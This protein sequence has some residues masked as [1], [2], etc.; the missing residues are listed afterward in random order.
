MIL[1]NL[2]GSYLLSNGSF[3]HF[4]FFLLVSLS[5]LIFIEMFRLNT[6]IDTAKISQIQYI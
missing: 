4:V 6:S 1:R 2:D 3:G 5:G